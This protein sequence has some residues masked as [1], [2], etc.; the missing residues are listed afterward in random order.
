MEQD[1]QPVIW[2]Q[3]EYHKPINAQYL[4]LHSYKAWP[5]ETKV[6]TLTHLALFHPVHFGELWHSFHT[7]E[8][9]RC[10]YD[11]PLLYVKWM[12]I[13]SSYGFKHKQIW[14]RCLLE[15]LTKWLVFSILKKY[16]WI[17]DAWKFFSQKLF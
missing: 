6:K 11:T 17:H 15:M 7:S 3:D 12:K 16:P 1:F 4:N 9:Q 2:R 5:K 13:A 14:C 8:T 10:D